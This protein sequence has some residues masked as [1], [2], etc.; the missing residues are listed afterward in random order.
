M[1]IAERR[2]RPGER[3]SAARRR[4]ESPREPERARSRAACATRRS[5]GRDVGYAAPV[6]AIRRARIES[7][8]DRAVQLDQTG[9]GSP[10]ADEAH[11]LG[12]RVSGHVPAFMATDQAIRD[13]QDEVNHVDPLVLCLVP[14][15]GQ[16]PRTPLR[17][18]MLGE[19]AGSLDLSAEPFQRLL[20]AHAG[21]EDHA[22]PDPGHPRGAAAGAARDDEPPRHGLARPHAGRRAACPAHGHPRREAG[23]ASAPRGLLAEAPG[24]PCPEASW[25]TSCSSTAIRRGTSRRSEGS[26]S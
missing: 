22:R 24:D 1:V 26:G 18:T 11:R 19:R 4:A 13:G 8:A 20:P 9:V 10:V 5:G 3:P 25:P 7:G 15:A 17:F 21:A 16:D 23:A 12:L 6:L 14:S 2:P